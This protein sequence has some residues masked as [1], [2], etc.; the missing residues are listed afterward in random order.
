MH[1]KHCQNHKRLPGKLSSGVWGGVHVG[2]RFLELVGE[3]S[4]LGVK[5]EDKSSWDLRTPSK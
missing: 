1:P 3:L 2:D 5:L 4:T